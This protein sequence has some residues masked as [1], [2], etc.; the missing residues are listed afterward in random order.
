METLIECI[1]K[2][3]CEEVILIFALQKLLVVEL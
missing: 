1:V 3:V 2:V